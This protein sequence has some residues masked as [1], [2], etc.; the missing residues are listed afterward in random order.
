VSEVSPGGGHGA[1]VPATG[2]ERL[3]AR[4]RPL[5]RE[6]RGRGDLWR[7]ETSLLLLALVALALATVNDLAR[8]LQIN[9]RLTADLR[10]W[11]TVTGN[12]YHNLSLQQDLKTFS[13]REV[14]CG[15]TSP[16]PPGAR[17]QV[18]LIMT[19]PVRHGVRSALGGFYLPPYL[20][21]V[22]E[23]RYAC[24]GTAVSER[25]C[26]LATPAGAPHAPMTG[27]G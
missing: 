17:P 4:L 14:V 26:G 25:L 16:G 5:E 3:P 23:H 8:Q 24:F 6:D 13:T 2:W 10:T 7:V 18:C 20:Q 21:D 27:P 19:G 22:R 9:G 1:R 11:R 12:Y 15:N